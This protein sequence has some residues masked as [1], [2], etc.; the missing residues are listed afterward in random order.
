M[1]EQ[2]GGWEGISSYWIGEPPQSYEGQQEQDHHIIDAGPSQRLLGS[3]IA[4]S[5]PTLDNIG[6]GQE[7]RML[8]APQPGSYTATN[9]VSAISYLLLLTCLLHG[10]I[11]RDSESIP[12]GQPSS[13]EIRA[14][15]D[16]AVEHSSQLPPA[17][18]VY[19]P[20]HAQRVHGWAR[21]LVPCTL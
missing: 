18:L 3:M 9:S 16:A 6:H 15:G 17:E 1:D 11:D 20:Y 4:T 14:N 2:S 5:T 13:L 8:H 19:K 10:V 7:G 12:Q 21:C